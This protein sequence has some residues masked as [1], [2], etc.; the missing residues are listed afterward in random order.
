MLP[1]LYTEGPDQIS[2][3]DIPN[4]PAEGFYSTQYFTERMLGFLK[5]R[6]A[7]EKG[8]ERP[9]F[10]YLPYTAPHCKSPP[11]QSSIRKTLAET[12]AWIL[13]RLSCRALAS[14]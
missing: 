6:K 12:P 4:I 1:P 9:F 10:A 2:H 7:D 13:C 5:D 8:E 11:L 14:A 3:K